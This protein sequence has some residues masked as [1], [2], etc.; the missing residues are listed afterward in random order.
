VIILLDNRNESGW[1]DQRRNNNCNCDFSPAIGSTR[2]QGQATTSSSILNA[3]ICPNC[4]LESSSFSL[5]TPTFIFDAKRFDPP[6]YNRETNEL[7]VTGS[8]DAGLLLGHFNLIFSPTRNEVFLYI[9][10]RN[11]SFRETIHQRSTVT[12]CS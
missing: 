6:R 2:C 12:A 4:N 10:T 7:Q 11:V 8:G 1:A 5:R 9:T 3:N